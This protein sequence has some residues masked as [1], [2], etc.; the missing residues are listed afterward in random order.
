MIVILLKGGMGN[1]MFQYAL[2]TKLQ[3]EG[4]PVALDYVSIA[5]EMKTIGRK[6]IF[7]TFARR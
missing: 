4:K 3:N 7:D 6:T 1:Q 2:Y 5:A